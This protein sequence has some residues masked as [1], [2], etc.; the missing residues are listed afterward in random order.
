[1]VSISRLFI[2]AFTIFSSAIIISFSG[3]SENSEQLKYKNEIKQ[4]GMNF[5]TG[6][7]F[8]HIKQGKRETV[9][10]YIKAGMDV[11][12]KHPS[13]AGND[14]SNKTALMIAS[15]KG[16]LDIVKI[17]IS[18]G[19]DINESYKS[20]RGPRM[21]GLT[22]LIYAANSGRV[23]VVRYLVEKGADV[24]ARTYPHNRTSLLYACDNGHTET[25]ELLIKNKADLNIMD[26]NGKT[27]L[28]LADERKLTRIS[29][30]LRSAGAR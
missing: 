4:K 30:M 16:D 19:A 29:A 20:S 13:R 9:E 27:P 14:F 22:P 12:K 18:H 7:F 28:M 3:C 24:N 11:N 23:A 21:E 6:D 15:D 10:L 17:L 26:A 25:A 1:M 2:L 5:T 8:N